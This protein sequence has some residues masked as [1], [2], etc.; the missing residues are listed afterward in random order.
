MEF[1]TFSGIAS[2]YYLCRL[3]TTPL[4]G[5][6]IRLPRKYVKQHPHTLGFIHIILPGLPALPAGSL[7]GYG[8]RR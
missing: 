7:I 1:A 5:D 3:Y 2:R 4:L 6:D 8:A